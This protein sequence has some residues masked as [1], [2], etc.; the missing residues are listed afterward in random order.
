MRLSGIGIPAQ[1]QSFF[2]A[3]AGI[4]IRRNLENWLSPRQRVQFLAR[5]YAGHEGL[6][7]AKFLKLF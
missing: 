1:A 4:R 3:T 6:P 5:Q 2:K 7:G